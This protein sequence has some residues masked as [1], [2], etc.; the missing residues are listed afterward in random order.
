MK[1][2][3]Y[4]P[5]DENWYSMPVPDD[6]PEQYPFTAVPIPKELEGKDV[7]FNWI[8]D[9]YKWVDATTD[10]A[11]SE[12]EKMKQK[13]E[14]QKKELDELKKTHTTDTSQVQDQI[15]GITDILISTPES[16][17]E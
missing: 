12:L 10:V 9:E 16:E 2:I 5:K 11:L 3:Y 17:A 1:T 14:T 13:F 8:G 4:A 6:F 15:V 7:K